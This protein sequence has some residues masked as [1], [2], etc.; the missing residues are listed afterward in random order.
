MQ[1]AWFD[2]LLTS[3]QCADPVVLLRHEKETLLKELKENAI[4]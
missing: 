2:V 1:V 3:K 4:G